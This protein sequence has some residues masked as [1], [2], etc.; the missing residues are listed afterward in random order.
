MKKNLLVSRVLLLVMII[1][2]VLL[3]L[4]ACNKSD[5][6]GESVTQEGVKVYELSFN[7]WGYQDQFQGGLQPKY[8]DEVADAINEKLQKDRGFRLKF[9]PLYYPADSAT[10]RMNTEL[11]SGKRIELLKA[12][13]YVDI[14][15]NYV[16][17]G[18]VTDIKPFLDAKGKYLKEGIEQVAWD[19]YTKD[20]AV[21][22]IPNVDFQ[23]S[24]GG[25]IRGDWLKA[26]GLETPKSF[27]ELENVLEKFKTGDLDKNGQADTVA[28]CGN[29]NNIFN[30]LFGLYTDKPGDFVENGN[31]KLYIQSPGFKQTLETMAS[32][33]K[34]GYIDDNIFED[35]V[36]QISA[37]LFS[38]GK[39]GVEISNIWNIEWGNLKSVNTSNPEMDL[40]FLPV[41][42]ESKA[43]MV[44]KVASAYNF[45]PKSCKYPEIVVSYLDWIAESEENYL[46]SQ[47]GMG[48][49]DKTYVLDKNNAPD[50]PP[51]EKE[52]GVKDGQILSGPYTNFQYSKFSFKYLPASTPAQTRVAYNWSLAIPTEKLY[53]SVVRSNALVLPQNV[54][55]K[56][57]DATLIANED[58]QKV[59]KGTMTYEAFISDWLSKGGKEVTDEYTKLY[60]DL[61]NKK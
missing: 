34:K 23:F 43:Y 45:I 39:T 21:Y 49:L 35:N 46:L 57:S 25:W 52:L 58:I 12:Q 20:G 40:R 4:P 50:I 16:E 47:A 48:I 6:G 51:A 53:R 37:N 8:Y 61:E 7:V 14:F 60:N 17:K 18:L 28:L 32:W 24:T 3:C 38:R 27:A 1:S 54:R 36:H 29:Y 41:P 44:E 59:I 56:S 33:Y 55:V 11:A 2:L 22:G 42:Q 26:L 13:N 10:E 9:K 30:Y 5:G 19:E 31:V 15:T